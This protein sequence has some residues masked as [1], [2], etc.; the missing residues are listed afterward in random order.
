MAFALHR[1]EIKKVTDQKLLLSDDQLLI[2]ISQLK[3]EAID[4]FIRAQK[5][6]NRN[7]EAGELILYLLT[8]WILGAPQLLAKMSLKTNRQMPVH[9][10]DGIHVKFS[11]INSTLAFY[12]G[13]SK[14][15]ED[16]SGAIT[17]AI[18]SITK[19]L[20]HESIK[21]ELTLIN[22]YIDFSDLQPN[23]KTE[24]LKYL[25]PFDPMSNQR[26]N[27]TTCLIGFDFDGFAK[28]ITPTNGDNA[29]DAFKTL[30]EKRLKA[31]SKQVSEKIRKANLS[32]HTIEMFFF[33]VPSVKTIRELFQAKIGWTNDSDVE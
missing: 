6:T 29:E 24:I 17:S 27:I 2:K 3:A 13:E 19:S 25:D 20:E 26:S 14:L 7:G 18:D 28:V 22:R 31:L 1:T 32:H 5:A 30:A 4:L 12:W 33:P 8:E 11:K 9:G 16:V 15:H 21:S 10:A 23:A